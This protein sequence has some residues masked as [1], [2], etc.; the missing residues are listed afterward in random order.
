MSK[1]N[2]LQ[3]IARLNSKE[4]NNQPKNKKSKK[5]VSK[6]RKVV[7]S[8]IGV[9]AFALILGLGIGVPVG[10]SKTSGAL[11]QQRD[12]NDILVSISTPTG[13]QNISTS[14]LLSAIK[15]TG[16]Q[17]NE[18]LKLAKKKIVEYLYDQEVE[19][20]ELFQ[21]AWNDTNSDKTS[22]NG[23][24]FTIK[25]KEDVR[26]EE[27]N[28]L[29]D[30]RTKFQKNFGF[31]NWETEFNK[32]LA[33]EKYGNAKSFDEAVD[34]LTFQA[35]IPVAFA[36]FKFELNTSFTNSDVTNRILK[37]DIKNKSGQVVFHK[38]DRLFKNIINL[39]TKD[40]EDFVN[41]FLPNIKN[42]KDEN[43]T[44]EE[45]EKSKEDQK[46]AAFLSKS[47]VK[48]YMY[49][50]KLFN[51]IYFN[52]GAV[53]K[54]NFHLFDMSKIV[55]NVKTDDKNSQSPWKIAKA[56]LEE[57]LTYFL[58]EVEP[59]VL[60]AK[61]VRNGLDSLESFKKEAESYKTNQE[62]KVLLTVI[63]PSTNKPLANSYGKLPLQNLSQIFENNS[64]Q[65]GLS[66]LDKLYKPKSTTQLLSKTLFEN[67]KSEVFKDNKNLL[68]DS[69]SLVG[70]TVA[71]IKEINRRLKDYIEKLSDTELNKAGEALKKTFGEEKDNFRISNSYSLTDNPNIRIVFD[72]KGMS[73]L[74]VSQIKSWEEFEKIIDKE[75]QL[76]A[77][78]QFD[79]KI[80]S[81]I[82][83]S[84]LLSELQN[85]DFALYSSIKDQKFKDVLL[86]DKNRT[87]AEKQKY[88]DDIT[89]LSNNFLV[90]FV[91]NK[92]LKI[93]SNVQTYLKKELETRL[94]NDYEFNQNKKIW[95]I[96]TQPDKTASQAILDELQSLFKV[97]TN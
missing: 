45:I 26:K 52:D 42:P 57:L 54:N 32:E 55:V 82:D 18:E 89:Q 79:N 76:K 85:D 65:F 25:S 41:G 51:E 36:R 21:K 27:E 43:K 39:A 10:A 95:V 7:Y 3:K 12:K 64:V 22:N 58:V 87:E 93:N 48:D 49:P 17:Q 96:K 67:I 97:G 90:S 91:I 92:V 59:N 62:D 34:Y 88:L 14:Q 30:E 83:L 8:I 19:N 47:F 20:A 56:D 6:K 81:N 13:D 1:L 70:K 28:K 23:K 35:L 86:A 16:E 68:P 33:T 80:N 63:N 66:F 60:K 74:K 50:K 61:V 15:T 77:N 53:L 38:G 84:S 9:G 40:G 94:I 31:N 11:V 72:D 78:N 71:E 75:L 4:K 37:N 69:S 24:T 29:K 5:P 46:V 2:L 44:P 73:I